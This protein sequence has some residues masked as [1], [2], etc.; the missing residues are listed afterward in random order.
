MKLVL[1]VAHSS[2]W[3]ISSIQ[4]ARFYKQLIIKTDFASQIVMILLINA[5]IIVLRQKKFIRA[6]VLN[7]LSY[8]NATNNIQV[9]QKDK[10][11]ELWN[12]RKSL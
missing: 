3:T 12:S 11:V 10:A 6:K 2:I 8:E 5:H 4:K 7:N 9:S 1:D